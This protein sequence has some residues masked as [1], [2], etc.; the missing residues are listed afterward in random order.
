LQSGKACATAR[1]EHWLG[2]RRTLNKQRDSS[3]TGRQGAPG[4]AGDG[5]GATTIGRNGSGTEPDQ[6]RAR[7]RKRGGGHS[8]D[9]ARTGRNAEARGQ[10]SAAEA[11]G[12]NEWK[13]TRRG[14]ANTERQGPEGRRAT[15]RL[16]PM[17][18]HGEDQQDEGRRKADKGRGSG[19]EK[20]ET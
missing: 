13:M 8:Q 2:R 14:L 19:Y 7:G 9:G 3:P 18:A 12:P 4:W 15:E 17:S 11:E 16:A 10:G 6:G 20:E 5:R 1:G